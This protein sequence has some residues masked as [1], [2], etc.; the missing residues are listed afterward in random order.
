M[1]LSQSDQLLLRLMNGD[2]WTTREL[3]RE[4]PC[5]VHSRISDLRAQGF[6]IEHRTTGVGAV[7]SE[8]RLIGEPLKGREGQRAGAEG[9]FGSPAAASH[10]EDGSEILPASRPL[11]GPSDSGGMALS[12][13]RRPLT[14]APSPGSEESRPGA[15]QLS[16]IE[17][18]A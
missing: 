1:S 18:A 17:E 7:G 12:T 13:S 11:S 15:G 10:G 6:T 5:I 3:L 16:L 4:V 2:W 8:Y 14:A 9:R